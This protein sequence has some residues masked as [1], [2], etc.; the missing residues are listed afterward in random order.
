MKRIFL[1]LLCCVAG[2][3]LAF[4][5]KLERPQGYTTALPGGKMAPANS[6]A[7]RLSVIGPAISP[8]VPSK[9]FSFAVTASAALGGGTYTGTILGRNPL[10]N[11]KTTTTIPTQITTVTYDPTA[12]DPCVPGSHST[13]D[14]V[15]GSPVFNNVPWTM[16]GVNIGNT[17]YIDAFQRAQFWSKVKGTPYHLILNQSTLGAQTLSFSGAAN[18]ANY[19]AADFV[20]GTCGFLGIVNTN[21]LDALLQGLITGPLAPMVN[22]GTFP[23]FLTKNVVSSESGVSLGGCCVLGYHS[24]L[25]VGVNLQIYSIFSIDSTGVFE[26]GYISTLSHEMAEAVNDPDTTPGGL[27]LTPPWGNIG[28]TVGQC[29]N[30]L[31]VGDPLS[32][33]FGTPTTPFVVAGSNGLTYDLQEL[34]Y[35]SWFFGATPLGVGA[36]PVPSYSNNGSFTHTAVLCPPGTP[37]G[38]PF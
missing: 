21:A 14:V 8:I 13:V 23:V 5:Q 38:G 16:N 26:A 31:E 3:S 2:A 33:G 6:A 28:Q 19:P 7:A 37:N 30:N 10:N 27:N 22:A 15:N 11:G 35:Y 29:Q 34:A 1:A 20:G 9:S 18:G 32:P 17:Q 12:I 4:G 36:G 24:S 25:I